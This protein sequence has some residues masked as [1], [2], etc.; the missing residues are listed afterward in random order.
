MKQLARILPLFFVFLLLTGCKYINGE[1]YTY[2]TVDHPDTGEA[3]EVKI[4]VKTPPADVAPLENGLYPGLIFVHGGGWN[5]GNR[6]EN[7]FDREIVTAAGHGYVAASIDYRLA[8]RNA[9]GETV[10]PWPA[11]IQDLKCAV[12]WLKSRAA[13]FQLDPE[14]I[15]VMGIS[16]GGHLAAMAA[17]TP[18]RND[19]EAPECDHDADSRVEAAVVFSGVVDVETT[20]DG[21][22]MVASQL[23]GLAATR[24]STATRFASLSDPVRQTLL[25]LDP[26]TAIGHSQAP[27]LLV[28]PDNDFLVPVDNASR[29]FHALQQ[30]GREAC[31]LRLDRGG[32]FTGQAGT[33]AGRYARAQMYRWLE[34]HI[35][36]DAVSSHCDGPR[37]VERLMVVPD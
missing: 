12:R 2:L 32:H 23:L 6:F 3:V 37:G 7:G 22:G 24:A 11:Q 9:Q 34:R 33:D 36:G 35:K 30:Q 17:E 18:D 26:K 5:A 29:Y 25:G 1:A 21:S 15:T 8:K 16:A 31:L 19:L 28:H 27:V 10:F 13:Q 14:R 20:W 4:Q